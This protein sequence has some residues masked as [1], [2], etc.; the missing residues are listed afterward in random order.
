MSNKI[1]DNFIAGSWAP[2]TEMK[3]NINP[4]NLADVVGKY[5]R[6]SAQQAETAIAAALILPLF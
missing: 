4:S 2:G 6:G 1:F 3:Q 5:A